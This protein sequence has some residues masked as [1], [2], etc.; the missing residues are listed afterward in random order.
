MALRSLPAKRQRHA[1]DLVERLESVKADA[2]MRGFATLAYF[3][4]TALIEAR[5]QDRCAGDDRPLRVSAPGA[6]WPR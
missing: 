2:E 1:D 4:E 3:V 5:L 6:H